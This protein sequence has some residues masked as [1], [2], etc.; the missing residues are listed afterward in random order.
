GLLLGSLMHFVNH[1]L[2]KITL[3]F[4]AGA[5]IT[6]TGIENVSKMDGIGRRMPWVMG[7]FTL[8]ALGMVGIIPINGFQSKWFLFQGALDAGLP[9][10]IIVLLASAILNAFYFFPIIGAAFFRGDAQW[11]SERLSSALVWAPV[12][13]AVL[14]LVFG[15][16][17]SLLHPFVAETVLSL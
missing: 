16:L 17:P 8:A 9:G 4:C 13:T 7:A 12:L 10:V 5:I 15:L 2:M 6:E 1:G 3:F 14:C 11:K